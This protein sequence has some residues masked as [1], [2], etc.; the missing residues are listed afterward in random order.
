MHEL[1][2]GAFK[3]YSQNESH[4]IDLPVVL[5]HGYAK[6]EKNLIRLSYMSGITA[7]EKK[8]ENSM[9][10]EGWLAKVMFR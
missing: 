3:E 5:R 7:Q 1:W 8:F 10:L 4:L 9:P 2:A 6:E